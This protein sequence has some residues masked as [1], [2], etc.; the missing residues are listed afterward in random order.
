VVRWV[1]RLGRGSAKRR[2]GGFASGRLVK[3]CLW[4]D[5]AASDSRRMVT[6]C[7]GGSRPTGFR[8]SRDEAYQCSNLD[9]P[10]KRVPVPTP[11]CGTFGTP[12]GCFP[13]AIRKTLVR[14]LRWSAAIHARQPKNG[15]FAHNCFYTSSVGRKRPDR[16]D[17]MPPRAREVIRGDRIGGAPSKTKICEV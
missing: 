4:L 1:D 5:T 11:H 17:R 8:P 3:D 16:A 6:T 2:Q 7:R 9:L 15:G 13:S 14:R 12:T 10:P